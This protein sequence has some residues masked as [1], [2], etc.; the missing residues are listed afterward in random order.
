[1]RETRKNAR[2]GSERTEEK[3]ETSL[4]ARSGVPRISDISVYL[5]V[6]VAPGSTSTSR[7]VYQREGT[8][9]AGNNQE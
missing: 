1:M 5:A 3:S 9:V 6:Y 7:L 8:P 4:L 2:G